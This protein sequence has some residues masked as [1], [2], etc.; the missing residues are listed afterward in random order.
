MPKVVWVRSLVPKEK[1]SAV[2]G[3]LAGAQR[4]AR[5]L[6]HG[7]DHDSRPGALLLGDH[8]FGDRVDRRRPS[9]AGTSNSRPWRPAGS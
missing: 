8:F 9:R 4:G 3:D 7:A 5:Q 6:D 2:L 1:N